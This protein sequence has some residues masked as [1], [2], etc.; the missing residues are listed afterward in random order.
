M[1]ESR[2]RR[3]R[4]RRRRRRQRRMALAAILLVIVLVVVAVACFSCSDREDPDHDVGNA[5]VT[6]T[7][8]T[9]VPTTLTT[10]APT[11]SQKAEAADGVL[12]N[13]PNGKRL[14][15]Y[16]KDILTRMEALCKAHNSEL[17]FYYKDL[18]NGYSME[19]RADAI[20]QTASV[21]KA[22]YVKCLLESGV[23]VTKSLVTTAK[24]GGSSFVDAQPLGTAF[25]VQ[26]LMEYAIRYSDNTAYYTLND[27]FGF[28]SFT[29]YGDTLG[30]RANRANGLTL[31]FPKPRFGY[32]SARDAGLYFEDIA[33]Y[34]D[35]GSEKS[36]W[37][38]QWMTTTT[39]TRQLTAAYE[40]RYA[41]AHKYGEQGDQAY[42]DAAIVYHGYPFVLV[43]MSTLPPYTEE[44]LTIYRELATSIEQLH[45][46]W[47]AETSENEVIAE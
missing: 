5:T 35:E 26:E 31:S 14:D 1:T 32:L 37:L 34:I 46:G 13:S 44:S 45:N 38:Y 25:T 17:S 22:P 3:E 42:H 47:Y 20:Y 27:E 18:T 12:I 19:Y 7:T 4:E 29:R 36:K 30:I 41:V 6:T 15:G 8:T 10:L 23:D 16:Y 39:E 40:G 43:V 24:Q 28:E 9:A 33:R 2:R 11:V 21:I